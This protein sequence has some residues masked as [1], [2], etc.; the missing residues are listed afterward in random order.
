MT[1]RSPLGRRKSTVLGRDLNRL[2]VDAA[3]VE[4]L[5]ASELRK[6]VLAEL[7]DR[8]VVDTEDVDRVL[9]VVL[10]L[11]A[12]TAL[13]RVTRCDIQLVLVRY[14][15]NVRMSR[16]STG[17]LGEEGGNG[18]LAEGDALELCV[19]VAISNERS[20]TTEPKRKTHEGSS[21]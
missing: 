6:A 5:L 16:T 4:A 21:G 15:G 8:R 10:D 12:R 14:E 3:L 11:P 19:R 20:T 7:E 13:R 2:G 1:S 17:N 18:Q 9:V